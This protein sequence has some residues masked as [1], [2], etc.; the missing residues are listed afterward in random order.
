MITSSRSFAYKNK[1]N[2][3]NCKL[4]GHKQKCAANLICNTFLLI[5]AIQNMLKSNQPTMNT[6][7]SRVTITVFIWQGCL[8][9]FRLNDLVI[10]AQNKLVKRHSKRDIYSSRF[11]YS[12]F[13]VRLRP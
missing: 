6:R 2:V 4:V 7:T 9:Y 8:R 11:L 5:L 13:T 1:P 10:K 3:H 12:R